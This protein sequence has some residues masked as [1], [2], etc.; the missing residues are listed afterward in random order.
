METFMLA[1]AA[2]PADD[3]QS[4]LR[5]NVGM[6]ARRFHSLRLASGIY[7]SARENH[8]HLGESQRIS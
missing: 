1:R 2:L 7:V 4:E 3:E 8:Q 6:R 5:S